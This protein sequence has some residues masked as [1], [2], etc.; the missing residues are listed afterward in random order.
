MS[1]PRY[2]LD[3]QWTTYTVVRG[4]GWEKQEWTNEVTRGVR[5]KH[6]RTMQHAS[7][8]VRK[9]TERSNDL[10]SNG[11]LGETSDIRADH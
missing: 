6:H 10:R 1:V 9:K 7:V 4:F 2:G 5:D 8:V 3:P 11:F